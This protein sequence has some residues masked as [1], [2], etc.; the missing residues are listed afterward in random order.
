MKRQ[1]KTK[2]Q[3]LT[4]QQLIAES[5]KIRQQIVL[6]KIAQTT[7]QPKDVH[8]AIKLRHRLAIMLSLIQTK[9]AK[10]KVIAPVSVT[11]STEKP[12]KSTPNAAKPKIAKRSK[13]DL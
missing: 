2:I 7:N 9:D 6:A 5:L 4:Q 12:Q 11:K 10:G 1:E 3:A 8:Q 13:K